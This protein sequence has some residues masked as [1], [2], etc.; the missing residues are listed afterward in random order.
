[1]KRSGEIQ[2]A[3]QK[4][5]FD[6]ATFSL[7]RGRLTLDAVGPEVELKLGPIDIGERSA[8]TWRTLLGPETQ[9]WQV[10]VGDEYIEIFSATVNINKAPQILSFRFP[11]S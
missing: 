10:L 1:M 4:Y 9:P 3:E 5:E 11:L 6:K 7:S 2:V 8:Q